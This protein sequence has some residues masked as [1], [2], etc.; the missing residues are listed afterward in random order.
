MIFLSEN[1]RGQV[2]TEYLMLVGIC[3]LIIAALTGY[4]FMQYQDTVSSSQAKET[5]LEVK[6]AVNKAYALGNG[7]AFIIKITIPNNVESFTA[8]DRAVRLTVNLFGSL[9]ESLEEVDTNV[10][11]V[12]P[13]RY[14][15]HDI[16]VSNNNGTVILSEA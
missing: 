8:S 16:L 14:G 10:S 9:S 13:T 5:M 11:G 2:A 3:L 4:A 7:N 12:L 15:P 1:N 6:E